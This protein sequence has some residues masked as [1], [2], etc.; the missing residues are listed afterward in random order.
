METSNL[1]AYATQLINLLIA[2]SLC[3]FLLKQ[4]LSWAFHT[5]ERSKNKVAG[6][7][8]VIDQGRVSAPFYDITKV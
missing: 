4:M 5:F 8:M 2:A 1:K 3:G 7:I 6:V